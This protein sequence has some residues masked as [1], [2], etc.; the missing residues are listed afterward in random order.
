MRDGQH[1]SSIFAMPHHPKGRHLE[2]APPPVH[3]GEA[4]GDSSP[5]YLDLLAF[6]AANQ[7]TSSFDIALP[8]DEARSEDDLTSCS[9]GYSSSS[10]KSF[11]SAHDI[12]LSPDA[13]SE[14]QEKICA[15]TK[16][17]NGQ[18][19]IHEKA[20]GLAR[21]FNKVN[22]IPG[23]VGWLE[24]NFIAGC[25]S[26][27]DLIKFNNIL[28][29]QIFSS[30]YLTVEG[31]PAY[32]EKWDG[33]FKSLRIAPWVKQLF[34]YP[35]SDTPEN[36][37]HLYVMLYSA[38]FQIISDIGVGQEPSSSLETADKYFGKTM[39]GFYVQTIQR[40]TSP[41]LKQENFWLFL[42][43]I[44]MQCEVKDWF[45]IVPLYYV[46][47]LY[48]VASKSHRPFEAVAD[49]FLESLFAIY[50]PIAN[51]LKS[52]NASLEAELNQLLADAAKTQRDYVL[53]LDT[54]E[55]FNDFLNKLTL[56]ILLRCELY[57]LKAN[58]LNLATVWRGQPCETEQA[59][60]SCADALLGTMEARH[61]SLTTFQTIKF[62]DCLRAA[63]T[64][65]TDF[66]LLRKTIDCSA[67]TDA[68][69]SEHTLLPAL[70]ANV[71]DY[72][73]RRGAVYKAHHTDYGYAAYSKDKWRPRKSVRQ[74]L[75]MRHQLEKYL[76][77][78]LEQRNINDLMR[79]LNQL[80]AQARDNNCLT[81]FALGGSELVAK[82][83]G[84]IGE[85]YA[86]HCNRPKAYAC[87]GL[88][89][90]SPARSTARDDDQQ[91]SGMSSPAAYA[92]APSSP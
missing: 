67:A 12:S 8:T 16:V 44:Q 45:S 58:R 40:P 64:L 57:D 7:S 54:P 89:P 17:E 79:E 55:Q 6:D 41:I 33:S 86:K 56:S 4:S 31:E 29:R 84:L 72:L 76:A 39:L 70:L 77:C 47:M 37:H 11:V 63:Q 52:A 10:I 34:N 75:A 20:D 9:E 22:E 62:K 2:G 59:Q 74:A 48:K 30:L 14:V 3:E 85:G 50:P 1:S 13:F 21:V 46:D 43:S 27:N 87:K 60:T 83:S 78:P 66:H 36:M 15:A 92:S 61:Q 82:T 24:P 18:I 25:G 26:L 42:H 91:D 23:L 51:V 88:M 68:F 28:Y 90:P 53:A 65:G 71:K 81:L 38:V 80:C 69:I 73:V 19:I 35:I 49:E 32:L 5:R